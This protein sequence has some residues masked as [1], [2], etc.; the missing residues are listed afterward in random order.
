[1]R[2]LSPGL[3]FFRRRNQTHAK[4]AG[5]EICTLIGHRSF[6]S[7]VCVGDRCLGTEGQ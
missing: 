5:A 3:R 6:T 1:M 4:K 2:P 7:D